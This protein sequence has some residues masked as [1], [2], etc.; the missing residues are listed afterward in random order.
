ME[1]HQNSKPSFLARLMLLFIPSA[2]AVF[3]SISLLAYADKPIQKQ[4]NTATTPSAVI[5]GTFSLTN[6]RGINVTETSYDGLYKLVFFGF[7]QCPDIC[8]TT[9]AKIAK[10]MNRFGE[11]AHNIKPLFISVD[12]ENDSIEK[13]SSYV[14]YFHPSIDGLTGTPS[15]LKEASA[16]FKANYGKIDSELVEANNGY[17]HSSYIYVMG[18]GNELLDVLSYADPTTQI[19]QRLSTLTNP[20][21]D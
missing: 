21:A 10:V 17:F 14:A 11:E 16:S 8:P 5:S 19:Y 2:L 1:H 13:L 9:L 12:T 20:L 18:P 7:T 4:V 6:H 3:F 15:Q